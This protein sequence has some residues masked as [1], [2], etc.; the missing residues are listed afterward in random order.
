[1]SIN[2]LFSLLI[3]TLPLQAAQRAA[4]VIGVKDYPALPAGMQLS[5]PK[6]DALDMAERL[7]KIGFV[8]HSVLDGSRTDI[9][10][11]K[12]RFL[13]DARGA[14]VA[15]FYFSGHGFQVGDENYLIPQDMPQMS[16]FSV[17]ADN[18]IKFR[19]SVMAGLEEVG[20]GTKVII[21]D[22]C[23]DN[24][25]EKQIA[26]ALN[27]KSL[28]TKGGGG[29]IT[30]YG[31]GFLLAFATSPGTTA[32]D[33][34][35]SR[36]SPF[37]A[38]LLSHLKD[39]SSMNIRELFD[40]VKSTV[41]NTLGEDQVPW[42]NDSLNKEHVKVL[43]MGA[44]GV[45]P[46]PLSPASLTPSPTPPEDLATAP[47]ALP[48][49]GYF[50]IGE[51]LALSAYS[52]YNDYSQR[53]ILK[54]AQMALNLTA[55]GAAGPRTQQAILAW[56]QQKRLPLTGRLDQT[57]LGSLGLTG[58]PEEKPTTASEQS[59]RTHRPPSIAPQPRPSTR[60]PLRLIH[61]GGGLYR[62]PYAPNAKPFSRP[63]QESGW[64]IAC[65]YTGL[66]CIV[67]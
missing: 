56:Q 63:G 43:A 26:A 34:N 52:G 32:L 38:A 59:V 62:S 60:G 58:L 6:S 41:K 54:K 42:V 16:S 2:A 55:D 49:S 21:L 36:N 5:S 44:A 20:A 24:P 12:T 23:R 50:G 13:E 57:T 10:S 51:L 25:F 27:T 45:P 19:E 46:E 64:E 14:Q 39:K 53:Q 22:C 65:P 7:Q 40:E 11:A 29:Q 66:P 48:A 33:G 37:T 30:G 67:P 8:V 15:V 18:A 35:G 1:M 28:R 9:L 61:L 17:L 4:F 47:P 31:P 3:F